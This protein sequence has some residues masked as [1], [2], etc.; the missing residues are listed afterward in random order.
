MKFLPTA[1]PMSDLIVEELEDELLIYDRVQHHAHRLNRAAVVVWRRCD[2][3]SR[4]DDVLLDLAREGIVAD[5]TVVRVALE[6][7]GE[8]HL[9]IEHDV[10]S[11]RRVVEQ[12]GIAA[13]VIIVASIA[14][15]MEAA[16]ASCGGL[17]QPCCPGN[18]CN[19]G[20]ICVSN[21]CRAVTAD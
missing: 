6:K 13:G 11:R 8:A 7:L 14:A 4:V 15:P 18:V 9:L 16:A 19:T 17:T 12:L 1:R 10:P 21:V 5:E 20:L 2:G 3:R